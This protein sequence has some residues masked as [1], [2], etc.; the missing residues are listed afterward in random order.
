MF[1][2]EIWEM[3]TGERKRITLLPLGLAIAIINEIV[4]DILAS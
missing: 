2:K 1:F 3:E 4:N